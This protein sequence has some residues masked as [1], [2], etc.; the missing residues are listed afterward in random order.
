MGRMENKAGEIKRNQR[1][2]G[3]TK[4]LG[5]CCMASTYPP[6]PGRSA[7]AV[8]MTAL[9]SPWACIRHSLNTQVPSESTA[10]NCLT[11][12]MWAHLISRVEN[13]KVGRLPATRTH[14]GEFLSLR[15][16]LQMFW[17]ANKWPVFTTFVFTNARV[18]NT[19]DWLRSPALRNVSCV[20]SCLQFRQANPR[21]RRDF[22]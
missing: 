1:K 17:T 6:A 20:V 10:C 13:G 5:H 8:V 14:N 3:G 11:P 7:G 9:L 2:A 12:V 18:F 16:G 21:G 4:Q 22:L 15:K 19:R